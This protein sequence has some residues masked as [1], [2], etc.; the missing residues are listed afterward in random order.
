M[1]AVWIMLGKGRFPTAE[2]IQSSWQKGVE[3]VDM[4]FN[5]TA[6]FIPDMK[7]GSDQR[8]VAMAYALPETT[9]FDSIV[10]RCAAMKKV[11]AQAH[12]VS[13]RN[14][15]VIIE[16]ETGTGKELI[17]RAIHKESD[18]K[19]EPFVA[20]NCGAIPKELFEAEFFGYKKGAFTG[21]ET[22]HAGYF[23]QADGGT[24]FLDELGE[25]PL[26]AQVKI[27]RI[28]NDGVVRRLAET[29][30]RKV[31]IRILAATNRN[32]L[33]EVSEGNFR[34]DLFY[35]LAVAMLKLPPLRER[36]GDLGL[37]IDSM[38]GQVNKELADSPGY[39]NKKFS[40]NAKNL[41]VR[42]TWPGNA[43]EMLNTIMRICVW[44]QGGT[45]QVEDVQQSLL[46]STSHAKD[47]ILQKPL[48][49]DFQLQEII[50][51]ISSEY[52]QK[53]LSE[54][55]GNMSKA[56]KLLGLNSYQTLK[57]WMEKYNIE[58]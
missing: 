12:L 19:Q 51:V 57:N 21:A 9:E 50:G 4:P 2:L 25:L 20:V 6:E 55:G 27:L 24:L 23:E 58:G 26:D 7:K 48:G 10:H 5:I 18:R 28:L 8:L 14:V 33:Q 54:A 39:K 41:M 45:I 42:H 35:R 53:A 46:P 43:R 49:G 56:A 13:S 30:D 15:P 34:A 11:I 1:A 52:I 22:E 47:D 44:C 36:E 16:G 38:L 32:L 29:K 31:D 3:R 17:A 37:L 40:I